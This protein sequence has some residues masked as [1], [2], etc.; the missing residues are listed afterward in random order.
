MRAIALLRDQGHHFE[1]VIAGSPQPQFVEQD[2]Y[3]R[4]LRTLIAELKL[5]DVVRID[6]RFLSRSQQIELIQSSHAGVFAYQD[7][8]QSSSGTIPL[9]MAT[10]RPVVCTPFEYA[11]AKRLEFGEG[12]AVA[13]DFG[14]EAVAEALAQVFG[15]QVDY[16][17]RAKEIHVQ[18]RTWRWDIVGAAY[19]EAF[20]KAAHTGRL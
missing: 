16:L 14:S 2:R 19:S 13:R 3:L 18:T 12:V 6:A 1:Y 15:S 17:R 8:D 7:S 20:K 10:G 5:V 4:E 9:V 11:L